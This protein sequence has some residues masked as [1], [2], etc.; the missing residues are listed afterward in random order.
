MYLLRVI[1]NG[2]GGAKLFFQFPPL[3]NQIHNDI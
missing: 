3:D 2:T 1:S